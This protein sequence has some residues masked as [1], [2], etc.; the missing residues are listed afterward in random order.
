[1]HWILPNTTT[2][3]PTMHCNFHQ[4]YFQQYTI[5]LTE[6]PLHIPLKPPMSG[7]GCIAIYTINTSNNT[8][9]FDQKFI[10]YSFRT[11]NMPC[12]RCNAI[13]SRNTFNNIIRFWPEI[14]FI[15]L[16]NH[17]C[18]D[19]DAL[20]FP[21]EILPTIQYHFDQKSIAYSSKTTNV[22]TGIHCSFH[23]EYNATP[24]QCTTSSKNPFP[25]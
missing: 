5:I 11:T 19:W 25:K 18:L 4:K 14:H 9:Y 23:V 20:Q 2:A 17:Q 22:W 12:Q 1:M 13:S 7:M 6:N 21:P 24:L 10:A 16:H 15:F 3:L 8:T